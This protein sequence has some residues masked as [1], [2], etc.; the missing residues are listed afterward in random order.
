MRLVVGPF[1]MRLLAGPIL[2]VMPV[3]AGPILAGSRARLHYDRIADFIQVRLENSFFHLTDP[4]GR[5]R[6]S[7]SG[8]RFRRFRERSEH[9]RSD[10]P[11]FYLVKFFASDC[12]HRTVTEMRLPRGTLLRD[13][14]PRVPVRSD[15]NVAAEEAF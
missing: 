12:P 5:F 6:R 9:E 8:P 11:D 10:L 4:E 2:F 1:V 15:F 14:T 3:L 7:D 13:F